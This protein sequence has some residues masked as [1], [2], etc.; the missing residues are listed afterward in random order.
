MRVLGVDRWFLVSPV[1]GVV[2]IG[3]RQGAVRKLRLAVLMAS[4]GVQL[5]SEAFFVLLLHVFLFRNQ[6]PATSGRWRWCLVGSWGA[7]TS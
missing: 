6:E 3:D 1:A 7:S 5:A 2:K 4:D